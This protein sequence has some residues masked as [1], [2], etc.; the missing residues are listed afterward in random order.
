MSRPYENNLGNSAVVT[1]ADRVT[2]HY[3]EANHGYIGAQANWKQVFDSRS[4]IQAQE[5]IQIWNVQTLL[6]NY[7]LP[8]GET[9][10]K[11]ALLGNIQ[12][13]IG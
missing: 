13:G 12:Y 6:G 5:S 9:G 8:E 4:G 3:G 7:E 10:R 1:Q 11:L 2:S